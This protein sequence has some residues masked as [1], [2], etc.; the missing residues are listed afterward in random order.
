MCSNSCGSCPVQSGSQ[1][2]DK[3][4]LTQ[5]LIGTHGSRHVLLIPLRKQPQTG[6][7]MQR[8]SVGSRCRETSKAPDGTLICRWRFSIQMLLQQRHHCGTITHLGSPILGILLSHSLFFL[9]TP[10]F[11]L[12]PSPSCLP[13]LCSFFRCFFSL[14]LEG[15]IY[16]VRACLTQQ[17]TSNRTNS[18]NFNNQFVCLTL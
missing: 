10:S 2:Y 7:V 14:T 9:L 3:Y 17:S 13:L 5:T 15:E 16:T 11:D 4:A 12:I 8:G 6:S 18:D 1:D